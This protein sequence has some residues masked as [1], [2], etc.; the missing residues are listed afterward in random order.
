MRVIIYGSNGWIGKKL[1]NYLSSHDFIKGI[2]RD[3]HDLER[4][5]LTIKPT[6]VISVIGRTHGVH[7]GR[8]YTTI[9]Y[10][11]QEGKLCENIRDNLFSPVVMALICKKHNIHFTYLGTGCIFEYDNLHPFEKERNG[12]TEDSKPNFFGSS[13]SIVKGFTDRLM[14]HIP[15]LN[16]RIRMPISIDDSPRNFIN[17][18]THYKKICSI[19]NSMTVLEDMLPIMLDM[20]EKKITGTFNFTNP[21]LIS[22]NE[23]LEMYREI[24]NPDFVWEN[25]SLEEQAEILAGG[26]SN[27]Y[28]D[29]SKLESL[30]DVPDIKTSVRTTLLKMKE[31]EESK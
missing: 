30:Y 12:F 17:K 2:A 26:R 6:H 4:E 23:I 29:T 24:I 9:D 16:L 13:Y 14:H 20:A 19:A 31:M 1:M 5:L 15:V 22:H 8:E 11:E 18:I 7:E 28:L 27:N 21:G 25:F 10:L 3:D